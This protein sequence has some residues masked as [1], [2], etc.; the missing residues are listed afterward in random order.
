MIPLVFGMMQSGSAADAIARY[1]AWR[2]AYPTWVAEYKLSVNNDPTTL[3]QGL[4]IAG[5]D[6]QQMFTVLGGPQRWRYHQVGPRSLLIS[7]SSKEYDFMMGFESWSAPEYLTELLELSYPAG[8][9][10]GRL[11]SGEQKW[12]LGPM[13]AVGSVSAVRLDMEQTEAGTVSVW[14]AEDG[15]LLRMKD[16]MPFNQK[17]IPRDFLLTWRETDAKPQIVPPDSY[18]PMTLPGPTYGLS[19]YTEL[20]DWD[21]GGKKL[22]SV[23]ERDFTVIV[24]DDKSSPM[25]LSE[26]EALAREHSWGYF[27]VVKSDSGRANQLVDSENEL[28]EKYEIDFVPAVMLVNREG[29]VRGVWKGYRDGEVAQMKDL[30]ESAVEN[31]GD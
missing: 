30:F 1:S 25:P 6:R 28:I 2:A 22:L 21:L 4:F 8:L 23:L 15:R 19:S 16:V 27:E 24:V 20:G 18:V 10:P 29:K 3:S 7:D 11:G 31:E 5:G 26:I 14:I 12:K 17:R 9:I 13:E